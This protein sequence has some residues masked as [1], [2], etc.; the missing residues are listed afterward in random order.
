MADHIRV[1]IRTARWFELMAMPAL[2][3]FARLGIRPSDGV[4]RWLAKKALTIT[5][6]NAGLSKR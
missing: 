5:P 6:E 4:V 3:F 1:T 2:L